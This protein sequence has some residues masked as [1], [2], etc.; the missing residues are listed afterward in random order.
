MYFPIRT[1]YLTW[2][3]EQRERRTF[4]LFIS[5]FSFVFLPILIPDLLTYM[6]SV[7]GRRKRSTEKFVEVHVCFT[8]LY[9]AAFAHL[10][11]PQSIVNTYFSLKQN[12]G[13]ARGR[14][15]VYLNLA[16]TDPVSQWARVFS[17]WKLFSFSRAKTCLHVSLACFSVFL[18]LRI[19]SLWNHFSLFQNSR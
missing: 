6:M 5:F 8:L 3:I 2:K 9:T 19:N 10:P 1:L 15:T 16:Y 11:L 18:R 7:F 13:L 17:F 14:W 12:A 4:C